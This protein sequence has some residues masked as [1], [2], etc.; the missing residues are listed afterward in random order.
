MVGV[1][2]NGKASGNVVCLLCMFILL[3]IPSPLSLPLLLFPC[4][5][6][7][8]SVL[9]KTLVTRLLRMNLLLITCNVLK[10]V[11]EQQVDCSTMAEHGHFPGPQLLDHRYKLYDNKILS[12]NTHVYLYM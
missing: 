9:R 6:N 4:T 2:H 10:G 8:C 5:H 3:L 1:L 7:S 11:C 12:K